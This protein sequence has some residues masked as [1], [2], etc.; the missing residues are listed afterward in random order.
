MKNLSVNRMIRGR[1]LGIGSALMLLGLAPA[2]AHHPMGGMTPETFTQGLLSGFGHP[3]IGLDHFAFLLV[4]AV[5]TFA[6]R[7]RERYLV[8]VAFVVAT[9]GGTL[10]HLA[11]ANL[12][13]AETVV[14]LSVLLAGVLA[15]SRRN[16]SALMLGSVFAV[17]GIFHGYAYGEAIVGAESTPLLAYLVGFAMIQYAIIVGGV[18]AIDKLAARSERLQRLAARLGSGIALLS[19]GAFLAL[20]LT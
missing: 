12:P 16:I 17:S 6:L 5:L 19:G 3:V 10:Y 4:A 15:L 13:L 8:P 11:A 7:G 2:H 20:S 9:V 14:A 18:I 1:G